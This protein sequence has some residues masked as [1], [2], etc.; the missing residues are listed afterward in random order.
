MTETNRTPGNVKLGFEWFRLA[1]DRN[2]Q[3]IY[4]RKTLQAQSLNIRS[5]II[6]AT[7][8]GL[9][10][11][12][13]SCTDGFGFARSTGADD[14]YHFGI[15]MFVN[16]AGEIYALPSPFYGV[17]EDNEQRVF[18]QPPVATF[19]LMDG[20][21]ITTYFLQDG[22]CC[23]I[24][25]ISAPKFFYKRIKTFEGSFRPS[26]AVVFQN[27]VYI[28]MGGSIDKK[29]I[30]SVADNGSGKARFT[31]AT[32]H[33][34]TTGDVVRIQKSTVTNYNGQWRVT[35]ISPTVFDVTQLAFVA[36]SGTFSAFVYKLTNGVL[37]VFDGSTFSVQNE[38]YN[39]VTSVS[40][41]GSGKARFTTASAHGLSV[42][43]RVF[44]FDFN[45][46]AYNSLTTSG[47]SIL[48]TVSDVPTSTAFDVDGIDFTTTAIGAVS[49]QDSD[50]YAEHLTVVGDLLVRAYQD[51]DGWKISRVD[52]VNS[53]P[54]LDANWTAGIGTLSVG[55][56]DAPVT[57]LITVGE[58]EVVL[59]AE[60][61]YTYHKNQ[62]AYMNEI[63][64]L[65]RH[66]NPRNGR[67]AIA[68]KGWLYIPTVIGLFRWQQDLT[69]N[70]TPAKDQ[71][72]SQITPTGPIGFLAGDT[73]ALYTWNEPFRTHQNKNI[74]QPTAAVYIDPD[75]S[76]PA[77]PGTDP[78][79][80]IP[81]DLNGL[82]TTGALYIGSTSRWHRVFLE[83]DQYDNGEKF[84]SASSGLSIVSIERWTGSS[85]VAETPFID[86]TRKRK[87]NAFVSSSL[88]VDGNIVIYT[89]LFN[90]TW[91]NGGSVGGTQGTLS[92]SYYWRRIKFNTA[93]NQPLI[94][95]RILIG[96]H[97][98]QVDK[99]PTNDNPE[100][101]EF[102]AAGGLQSVLR[103]EDRGARS[104]WQTLWGFTQK[105]LFQGNDGG[106]IYCGGATPTGVASI[107]QPNVFRSDVSGSR[108]LFLGGYHTN[109]VCPLGNVSNPSEA[110]GPHYISADTTPYFYIEL[111]R[112]V[113]GIVDVPKYVVEM[114]VPDFR[115]DWALF[116]R[117]L[118]VRHRVFDDPAAE[119]VS[120]VINETSGT[121]PYYVNSAVSYIRF[122][123][124]RITGN[125]TS[126]IRIQ[127]LYGF[128]FT[129]GLILSGPSRRLE[130]MPKLRTIVFRALPKPNFVESVS[131]SLEADDDTILPYQTVRR[132]FFNYIHPQVSSPEPMEFIDP[133]G[134][135]Y[136]FAFIQSINERF[137]EGP[138]RA[139]KRIIDVELLLDDGVDYVNSLYY[140]G[141]IS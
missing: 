128:D 17:D 137:I 36:P 33:R 45:V 62:G 102:F 99:L 18:T 126:R 61:V 69:E 31:T 115:V 59:K 42:G 109:Y 139:L 35:V 90:N 57:D 9:L 41:N 49:R 113:F 60:G 110:P 135:V 93:I 81:V 87:Q 74:D 86:Y 106:T 58:G 118:I 50:V 119:I 6:S 95:K 4:Q 11:E 3:Y 30:V 111:P 105:P 24:T 138:N 124:Q 104:V 13:H 32:A 5:N 130:K 92:S 38:T 8:S 48:Y 133:S 2:N 29:K 132:Y 131:M 120:T 37:R 28:A 112:T 56:S 16:D 12:R 1:K 68:Y 80:D 107:I 55:S 82:Q 77:D 88:A 63:P 122:E 54:T 47:A 52:A 10:E 78:R 89:N 26:D 73:E 108:W 64:E 85:W 97:D 14:G 96:V 103:F 136:K 23:K 25:G 46:A 84:S 134:R 98:A 43:D 123:K 20:E 94:I 44:L 140:D 114:I 21:K 39:N 51:V 76:A 22:T 34:L 100:R 116:N 101:D 125:Y 53:D 40:N 83:V 67:G 79:L 65:E 121:V 75:G 66:L 15:N 141:I 19:E 71:P 91:V 70:V 72:I 117:T 7:D 129:F 127:N 27:R